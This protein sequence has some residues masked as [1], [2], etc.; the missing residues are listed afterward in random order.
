MASK[1]SK[2]YWPPLQTLWRRLEYGL[3]NCTR[4]CQ[5]AQVPIYE[6]HNTNSLKVHSGDYCEVTIASIEFNFR[7]NPNNSENTMTFIQ[8]AGERT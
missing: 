1:Y 4:L 6:M 3:H 7:L 2:V 5:Q 8:Y